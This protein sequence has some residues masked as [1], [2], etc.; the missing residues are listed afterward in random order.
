M[1]CGRCGN[2]NDEVNR[3]CGMCGAPL[4]PATEVVG[5][6]RAQA[7]P[8]APA[9][10]AVPRQATAERPAP[11]SVSDS[12]PKSEP[13]ITGPSF[14]GL[15][16][17]GPAADRHD[18]RDPVLPSFRSLDYLLDDDEEPKRSWGKLFLFVVALALAVGFGYLRW[19]QGGFDWLT[20][21][22][23]PAAATPAP[24]AAQNPDSANSGTPASTA[25]P[26]A[27]TATAPPAS[28][29]TTSP[30]DSTAP[31]PTAQQNAAQP[32]AQSPAQNAPAQNAPPPAAA[33]PGSAGQNTTPDT[34]S[35]AKPDDS[36]A[37]AD[38]A[39]PANPDSAPPAADTTPAPKAKTRKPAPTKPS[40]TK[41][42]DQVA[43]AERYIYA[44]GPQQDCDRGLRLLKQAAQQSNPKA[45]VS[46]GALYST[47]T[48]TPRD[49]PTAYRWFALALHQQPDNQAV[50]DDLKNLWD[51]MTQPERQLAIKLSQ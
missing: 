48:C 38:S 36:S 11:V 4:A 50:Q 30:A 1:R 17:P 37:P 46:M 18:V 14:L 25:P 12:V 13:A 22:K 16:T 5:Q 29:A 2:D 3:F 8:A 6:S 27:P 19:K 44:R 41:A 49:L 20:A 32:P 26:P 43:E 7:H 35:Q 28:G 47:G 24:D 33:A 39:Q 15:S 10:N 34:S 31:Q 45:M 40:A 51:K 23:K 21:T 42:Y 9:G